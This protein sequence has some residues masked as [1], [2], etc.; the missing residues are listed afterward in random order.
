MSD[1]YPALRASQ[2]RA[3][4]ATAEDCAIGCVREAREHA[5]LAAQLRA[6]GDDRAAALERAA[7]HAEASAAGWIRDADQLRTE[8]DRLPRA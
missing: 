4:I 2:L 7:I 3:A 8:L 6:R 5:R 1:P